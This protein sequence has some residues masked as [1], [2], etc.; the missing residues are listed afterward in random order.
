MTDKFYDISARRI[1]GTEESLDTFAGSAL[2]VVNVASECGKT[3]QY[4][5]L[6]KLY[7]AYRDRGFAVLGFPCNQ[8]GAQ[9]PGSET[10]ILDFCRSVYGV[11]F[12]MFAKIDVKGPGQ[13]P[14]Y[15]LMTA[16]RPDRTV[17]EG[18]EPKPGQE[19]RWNFEKF[20]SGRD[21]TVVDRFDPDI[22]PEDSVLTKAIEAALDKPA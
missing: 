4:A 20:L 9:E 12:P 14:L 21:G 11:D 22:E 1:D 19:V 3:P 2:L 15:R 8:F 5:G 7:H 6:E 13:H 10:E 16:A 18:S 17:A